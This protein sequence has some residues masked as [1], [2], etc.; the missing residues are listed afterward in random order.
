[1]FKVFVARAADRELDAGQVA[2]FEAL[3][4]RLAPPGR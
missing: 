3:R 2:R 4:D 1:M